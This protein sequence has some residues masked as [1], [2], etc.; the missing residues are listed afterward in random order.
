MISKY[1]NQNE[2]SDEFFADVQKHLEPEV[3]P[4]ADERP[5]ISNFAKH[6]GKEIGQ[7]VAQ[8]NVCADVL[9]KKAHPAVKKVD[10]ILVFIQKSL[11]KNK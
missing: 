7:I 4:V 6:Y 8:L 1:A 9:E 2:K 3:A 5:A 10:E 11:T